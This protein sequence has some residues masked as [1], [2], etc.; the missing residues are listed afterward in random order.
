MYLPLFLPLRAE[1]RESFLLPIDYLIQQSGGV[2]FRFPRRV[3]VNVHRGTDIRV[4]QQ[5][6]HV[7]GSGPIGQEVARE[8]VPEH[9]EMEV[10]QTR[11]LLL[12]LA[13]HDA[14]R[15]RCFNGP[16]RPET[17]KG[18]LL[19]PLRRFLYPGQGVDLV[20]DAVFLP[21]LG[22]VVETV[23]LTICWVNLA[24]C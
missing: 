16:V 3:C 21:D 17:D 9:M 20:I 18:N 15:T 2:A 6:L 23:E 8:G 4:P 24:A 10:R 5:F 14:Y 12:C 11:Y 7:L 19:V 1:T 22:V 13:A